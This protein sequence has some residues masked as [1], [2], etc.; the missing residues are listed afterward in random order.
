[1]AIRKHH[2]NTYLGII[3]PVHISCIANSAL[4]RPDLSQDRSSSGVAKDGYLTLGLEL[5]SAVI[6]ID[7]CRH[8]DPNWVDGSEFSGLPAPAWQQAFGN[9]IAPKKSYAPKF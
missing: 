3:L 9:A 7:L 4:T 1:V 6:P 5:A 2:G 8:F